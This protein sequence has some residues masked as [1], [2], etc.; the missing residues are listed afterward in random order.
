MRIEFKGNLNT[1]NQAQKSNQITQNIPVAGNTA[2]TDI[3]L[4]ALTN[5]GKFI[6]F[7][8]KAKK[9]KLSGLELT[10]TERT[11]KIAELKKE[12]KK[13]NLDLLLIMGTDEYLN[14][15]VDKNQSQRMYISGFTGSAGDIIMTPE[16]SHLIVDS[17]YYVQ[18]DKEVDPNHY[19]VEKAGLD[20]DGNPIKEYPSE[21]FLKVITKL[22]KA[23][24]KT[25]TVG[26]DPNK[27]DVSTFESIDNNLKKVGININWLPTKQ[28]LVDKVRGGK[29][30]A[31]I[32]PLKAIP[33]SLVGESTE[34]KLERLKDKLYPH[35][36]DGIIIDHLCDISY[37]TN[38][39]GS[40]IDYNAAFKAKAFV[41]ED[42]MYVFCDPSKVSDKIKADLKDSVIFKP[43]NKYYET[44]KKAVKEADK[45]LTICYPEDWTVLANALKLEE[46]AKDNDNL[47]I[48]RLDHNP[49][50]NMR[51]IKNPVELASMIDSCNRADRAVA[52]VI[53]YINTKIE[54][55]EKIT[56]K[57]LEEKMEE[58]HKAHGASM[59]SF[60][61]IPAVGPNAAI[62]H[63]SSADPKVVIKPGD[64]I[65]LDTGGYYDPGYATDLTRSWLAGGDFGV[66]HL[67]DNN[68]KDLQDKKAVYSLVLKGAL[69]GL[70]AELS[71]DM[72]GGELDDLIREPI[73]AAG[74]NYGHGTGHG[75]GIGVH[76]S[77]PNISPNS[78]KVLKEGMIFS[79]EPGL[80]KEGW[81]GVRFENLVTVVP[82]SDP[83]K[84]AKG[85]HEIKCVTFSP[86]DENLLDANILDEKD[87]KMIADFQKKAKALMKEKHADEGSLKV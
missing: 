53:N 28:N 19:I 2:S 15:T 20:P 33:V 76:E 48:T 21:R 85:W 58:A 16:K 43:E 62:V 73:K 51:V 64:L 81:G 75:V 41:I 32:N 11:A 14:E 83:D 66:K 23:S 65:L 36:A 29:P 84:A 46:L 24:N 3:D 26:F 8:G 57:D 10:K 77:P 55:G 34:S 5:Y 44:F 17:R 13:Q 61:T 82:H 54:R 60:A 47:T 78:T 69:Q 39:R 86:L 80:Y 12:M 27:F 79:I 9:T 40:D 4:R 31:K 25:L 30:A 68:P 56:E 42:K 18:A 49:I 38:L 7:N 74:E 67:E 22:A 70:Y 45:P 87:F 6:A 37:L 59:L 1:F 63:Y 72:T 35:A 50:N 71:P 52:D